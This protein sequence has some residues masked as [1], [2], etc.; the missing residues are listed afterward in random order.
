MKYILNPNIALRSWWRVPYAFYIKGRRDA[1]GLKKEQFDLL[2]LCDGEHEFTTHE[3]MDIKPLVISGLAMPAEHGERL[4]EW[5]RHRDC[6]NRYFPSLSWMIT[7]RCNFNCLHCFN[8]ADNSP[9]MSEFSWD[10]ARKLIEEAEG[11]GI[12]AFTITGGE[13]MLHR[14]FL[15][16]IQAIY[17]HGMY[18]CELNTNGHFITVDLLQKLKAID[19]N[20]RI[21]I[22]FDGIG[23]HDWLRNRAGAEQ[24]A[25]AAIRACIEAGFF[26]QAQTNV[27]RGN[28][29]TLL[30]T[31]EM[32][33]GMGVEHMRIIRTTEAPRWVQN[34]GDATLGIGEYYDSMIDFMQAYTAKEHAMSIDI[35]QVAQLYPK[36]H[37]FRARPVECA[38]G[39]YRDTFPVCRGNRGMVSVDAD[40]NVVPCHQMS[41]YY[42]A[43]GWKLGN[44]KEQ[45]LQPLLQQG[46][47]IDEV[48]TTLADLKEH[49]SDCANCQYFKYCAGGCRAI[50]LAFT[51]DKL[52]TDSAKC[53]FF[54]QGYY[55]KLVQ[56]LSGWRNA[57][58]VF[59]R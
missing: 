21:K 48:C 11:C 13:P 46:K 37:S 59:G 1:Q 39:E 18:V 20:I 30:Q 28:L 12:N 44:V 5:Q 16:I 42:A 10:E 3:L 52:G 2:R 40:G 56:A 31:A 43:H 36:S 41:G 47:Y 50:A 58:P 23:H 7:G 26:V 22:S 17:D 53:K 51:G 54:K 19:G 9:L 49:N 25:L 38:E 45:G 8:A 57:A 34:A 6:D 35:W 55:D 33:D 24:E 4:T 29:D 32:L 15:D 27:H 14:H